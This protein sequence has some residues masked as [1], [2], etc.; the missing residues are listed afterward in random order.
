MEPRLNLLV[1]VQHWS[2]CWGG[3]VKKEP[4]TLEH[5][6]DWLSHFLQ[7]A[8]EIKVEAVSHSEDG[9]ISELLGLEYTIK[10]GYLGDPCIIVT[11]ADGMPTYSQLKYDELLVG[12]GMFRGYKV[13]PGKSTIVYP[14]TFALEGF[15]HTHFHNKTVIASHVF[16][17]EG[18]FS[19]MVPVKSAVVFYRK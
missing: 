10:V 18:D 16:P 2:G 13:G 5:K 4:A 14:Y 12:E 1:E 15:S 9:R 17:K 6:C 19:K 7:N 3:R 8:S 11:C